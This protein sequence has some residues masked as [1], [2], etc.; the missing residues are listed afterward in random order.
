MPEL[1]FSQIS[2]TNAIYQTSQPLGFFFTWHRNH[3]G[4]RILFKKLDRGL[5]NVEWRLDFPE[6]FVD[7]TTNLTYSHGKIGW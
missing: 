7:T 4:L 6:A 1:P 3:N 2:W 5:A